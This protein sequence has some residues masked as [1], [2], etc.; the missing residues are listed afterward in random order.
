[1][2]LLE[3]PRTWKRHGRRLGV[4]LGVVAGATVAGALAAPPAFANNPP[5]CPN[6]AFSADPGVTVGLSGGCTDT[7]GPSALTYEVVSPAS[8][9]TVLITPSG[10]GSTYTSNAGFTG[11]DSFTYRAFD[12][13]DYSNTAT[14][15][16]HVGTSP[17]PPPPGEVTNQTMSAM[18][19]PDAQSASSFGEAGLTFSWDTT[20][21]VPLPPREVVIHFDDDIAFDPSGL[22]TCDLSS[23]QGVSTAQAIA[24]CPGTE[25]GSGT[26]TLAGLPLVFVVTAF[27]AEPSGGDPQ[28]LLHVSNPAITLVFVAAIRPSTHGPDYGSE[29][30][31]T[32]WP[33]TPGIAT[34]HFDLTFAAEP[35]PGV[36]Y[37]TARCGDADQ[38]W[39]FAADLTFYDD[40]T[41]SASSTQA[42]QAVNP[43]SDEDGI[44]DSVD[45]VPAAQSDSFNDGAGTSGTITD[46]ADLQVAIKDA[47]NPSKG[48]HVSVGPGSGGV[49]ID[50]CGTPTV[51]TAGTEA[52][53][54][55]GS[56]ILDVSQGEVQV[57]IPGELTV[58]SVPAGVSARIHD[59]G[60]GTFQVQNFGGGDVTVTTDGVSSTVGS[61]ASSS[62]DGVNL[63]TNKDQ[64]KKD[65]WR[66][67]HNGTARFKNQG[68]CVSFVATGGKNPPAG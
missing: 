15:T 43:D 62:V 31:I 6:A 2:R 16:V 53:L 49:T 25:V 4:L 21:S 24:A 39:N 44:T 20:Y 47:S 10:P 29:L 13:A 19:T 50:A 61:G 63:P 42:C 41:Q 55:C 52:D 59:N 60:D 45:T 18:V 37:V 26:A 23:I 67:F 11:E 34:G 65:G 3:I 51:F 33:N 9:G 66:A 27:N 36:H 40:S 46:R 32:N 35:A 17:P 22:A 68:D 5:T 58:I 30:D 1:M 38:T 56:T 8:H 57:L 48:V 64:C 14:V 28:I 54:T 12:G 7:D